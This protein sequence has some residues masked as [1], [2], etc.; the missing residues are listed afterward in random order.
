MSEANALAEAN[1]LGLT[2]GTPGLLDGWQRELNGYTVQFAWGNG[3]QYIL[4]IPALNSVV[5]I[6][7]NGVRVIQEVARVG[8]ECSNLLKPGLLSTRINEL[9]G[10]PGYCATLYWYSSFQQI[11]KSIVFALY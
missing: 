4:M 7:S 9:Q 11:K 2:T 10:W 1:A 5:V 8:D 6:A 3:G